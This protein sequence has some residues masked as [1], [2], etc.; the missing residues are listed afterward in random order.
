MGALRRRM[1]EDL[2]LKGFSPCTQ[3]VYLLYCQKFA[4]HYRRSPSDLGEEEIRKFLLHL[5]CT[6]SA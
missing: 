2:K 1:E 3:K 4:A 5:I 6:G